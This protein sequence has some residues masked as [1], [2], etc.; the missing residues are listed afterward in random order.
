LPE[1]VRNGGY[2]EV[3]AF[4]GALAAGERPRPTIEDVLPSVRICFSIAESAGLFSES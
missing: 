4:V 3:V 1:D 2:D